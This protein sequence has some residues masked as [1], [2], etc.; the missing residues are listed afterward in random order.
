[1][2]FFRS[3]AKT[4][5]TSIVL[6]ACCPTGATTNNFAAPNTVTSFTER[7]FW[8]AENTFRI[9]WEEPETN[10]GIVNNYA[11]YALRCDGTYTE[12]RAV[13]NSNATTIDF[14]PGTE[15]TGS[16]LLAEHSYMFAVRARTT[17]GGWDTGGWNVNV[18][19]LCTETGPLGEPVDS[20]PPDEIP[21]M[22]PPSA[23][24]VFTGTPERITVNTINVSWEEPENSTGTIV[25]YFVYAYLCDGTPLGLKARLWSNNTSVD[26]GPATE[27]SGAGLTEG[28]SYAF[29]VRAK[30][31]AGWS[32]GLEEG[33]ILSPCS[34]S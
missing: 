28:A 12:Q 9:T 26:F 4:V 7:P 17:A 22:L 33:R 21:Q 18:R 25:D 2:I 24:S 15:D 32:E 6:I 10:G 19:S 30:N 34:D 14:G 3:L 11:V 1:M 20:T 27:S 16:I 5:I 13:T 23:V 8:V 29:A 31:Q